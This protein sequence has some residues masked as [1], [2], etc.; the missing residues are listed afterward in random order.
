[1]TK[2]SSKRSKRHTTRNKIS[3]S[4]ALRNRS[5][6]GSNSK[7][8]QN[9]GM[10]YNSMVSRNI[11]EAIYMSIIAGQCSKFGQESLSGTMVKIELNK[12]LQSPFI[13]TNLQSMGKQLKNILL[14]LVCIHPLGANHKIHLTINKLSHRQRIQVQIM[15]EASTLN[16]FIKEVAIQ[17]DIYTKTNILGESLCPAIVGAFILETNDPILDTLKTNVPDIE[18]LITRL[19]SSS[20]YRVGL[21]AMELLN[22]YNTLGNE[23]SS[24]S[25]PSGILTPPTNAD[26][27]LIIASYYAFIRL[28]SIGYRHNDLHAGN[29]MVKRT[30]MDYAGNFG[31]AMIIDFGRT[32]RFGHRVSRLKDIHTNLVFNIPI[33]QATNGELE[34]LTNTYIQTSSNDGYP[35]TLEN[36]YMNIILT[37]LGPAVY[38]KIVNNVHLYLIQRESQ[39][40]NHIQANNYEHPN[41]IK[42][43]TTTFAPIHYKN[44]GKTLQSF[45]ELISIDSRD[46]QTFRTI[47]NGL[48]KQSGIDFDIVLFTSRVSSGMRTLDDYSQSAFYKAIEA[49]EYLPSKLYAII[50]NTVEHLQK[51]NAD[52]KNMMSQIQ[53]EKVQ[54]EQI[55]EQ[56]RIEREQFRVEK[57]RMEQM[58][59]KALADTQQKASPEIHTRIQDILTKVDSIMRTHNYD[60]GLIRTQVEKTAVKYEVDY[61]SKTVTDENMKAMTHGMLKEIT[62]MIRNTGSQ[63][64]INAI[65]VDINNEYSVNIPIEFDDDSPLG[66]RRKS[67]VLRS[68]S[69]SKIK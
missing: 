35:G 64:V 45:N 2:K 55:K 16:D 21:I 31:R 12:H 17:Q 66:L 49:N 56:F 25:N 62:D 37:R 18:P 20:H 28:C 24:F 22:G 23:C 27:N 44:T 13:S 69:K 58:L 39:I 50:E 41:G 43:G 3:K 38:S 36:F 63:D 11:K 19:Q 6:K 32:T 53:Q 9:G 33:G 1:M 48:N 57:E 65:I 54:A 47:F 10:L 15:K 7:K 40:V 42:I 68:Q 30:D 5:L 34:N 14:K 4:S 67:M 46:N 52:M 29:V 51:V 61:T 60:T 26:Y 59:Q 8:Q